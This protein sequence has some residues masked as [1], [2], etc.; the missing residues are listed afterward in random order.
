MKFLAIEKENG[1]APVI[2]TG[3]L[4]TEEAHKAHQLYLAGILR[5]IYFNDDHSA[6]LI[7]ECAS[8]EMAEDSLAGLPLVQNGLIR[9]ELME[10]RPYTGY[11]R[12]IKK[13]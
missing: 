7:L 8:M 1:N 12:I 3:E 2:Y 6:V 10:L 13:G 9:F 11:E 5:E 4:L